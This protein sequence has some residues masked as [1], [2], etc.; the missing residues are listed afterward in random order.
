MRSLDI[1][2][3][4]KACRNDGKVGTQ[5]RG[6]NSSTRKPCHMPFRVPWGTLVIVTTKHGSLRPDDVLVTSRQQAR[7]HELRHWREDAGTRRYQTFSTSGQ[8]F[9]SSAEK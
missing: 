6:F 7:E 5:K 8:G 1:G 3:L 2:L 9:G 4:G